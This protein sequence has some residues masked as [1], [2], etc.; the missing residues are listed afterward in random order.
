MYKVFFN[1][2]F[3]LLTTQIIDHEDQ[4]PLFYI[5][6]IDQ[7]QIIS[8]LKSKKIKGIYLYHAKEDKLWK[9]MLKIFSKVEAAGGLVEHRNGKFLFIYRNNK[10]DLPKGKIEKKEILIDGAVREVMEETGVRDLI[11]KK[12]LNNTFHLFSKNGSYKLKKTYWYLMTTSY[13]GILEPQLEEG[14]VMADWKTK[15]EVPDLMENAYPNIKLLFE[16]I[17]LN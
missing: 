10:W 14:I 3:V 12:S 4:T 7:K 8:A 17:D 11:V 1:R 13:E 16:E 6:F 15:E 5:K 9:H 2:K